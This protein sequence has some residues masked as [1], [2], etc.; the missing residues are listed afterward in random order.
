MKL[1]P[2]SCI[3]KQKVSFGSIENLKKPVFCLDCE[4]IACSC[5]YDNRDA[6]IVQMQTS[7]LA[8]Y[9]PLRLFFLLLKTI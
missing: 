9:L 3:K 7:M 2:H 5:A 4:F 8:V 1:L 6:Q